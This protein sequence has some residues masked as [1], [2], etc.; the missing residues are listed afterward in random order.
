MTINW[1]TLGAIRQQICCI[2]GI[3]LCISIL[4]S[5]S[6]NVDFA[7]HIGGLV[8]GYLCGI[9]VFP[10]IRPKS[11]KFSI[12]GSCCLGV[13]ILVMLLSFYL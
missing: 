13:Y 8:G 5:F 7:G 9:A 3:I 2:L 6:G 10:G 4:S 11:P 1:T 12:V